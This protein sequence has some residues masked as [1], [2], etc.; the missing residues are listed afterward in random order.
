MLAR[1]RLVKLD[2]WW[3]D[4]GS[5][6]PGRD[7]IAMHIHD[8]TGIRDHVAPGEGTTNFMNLQ[9]Q[10]GRSNPNAA[11]TFEIDQRQTD[12]ALGRGLTLLQQIGIVL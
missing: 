2:S 6:G 4:S 1:L 7:L 11:L 5:Y 10:I 9:N 12:L 8:T 3:G